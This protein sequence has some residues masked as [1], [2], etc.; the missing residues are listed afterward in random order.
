MTTTRRELAPRYDAASVEPAIYERWMESG[1][2]TPAPTSR[3][4]ARI[5]SSSSSRRR[6]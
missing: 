2:F 1:A 5:G 3:R 6:T 4:R